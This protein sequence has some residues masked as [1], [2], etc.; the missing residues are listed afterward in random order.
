MPGP[1]G[2]A[3][4]SVTRLRILPPEPS[5]LFSAVSPPLARSPSRYSGVGKPAEH[6]ANVG[7][8]GYELR[9]VTGVAASRRFHCA[10]SNTALQLTVRQPLGLPGP[11][12]AGRRRGSIGDSGT[13][14]RRPADWA[15]YFHGRPAAEC[16]AVRQHSEPASSFFLL[17]STDPVM[18]PHLFGWASGSHRAIPAP[19]HVLVLK[20]H[21]GGGR[22]R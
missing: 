7:A 8:A 10:L 3:D 14:R 2:S 22:L 11:P 12:A 21:P 17:R 19:L 1:L 18:P 13:T 4:T 15:W 20:G 16:Q 6:S 9:K 5:V